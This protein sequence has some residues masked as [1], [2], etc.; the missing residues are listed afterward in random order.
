MQFT[1]DTICVGC[2]ELWPCTV[3]RL[4]MDWEALTA[5]LMQRTEPLRDLTEAIVRRMLPV[6]DEATVNGRIIKGERESIP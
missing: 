3:A 6:G 4:A 1:K 5:D 2:G